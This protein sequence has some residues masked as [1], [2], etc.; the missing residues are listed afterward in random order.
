MSLHRLRLKMTVLHLQEDTSLLVMTPT[1]PALSMFWK[2][3][4]C[5][6]LLL[7]SKFLTDK[8]R[9]SIY[10]KI[11]NHAITVFMTGARGCILP[12]LV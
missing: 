12:Y 2:T 10:K 5:N 11:I 8:H 4:E 1:I 6:P 9:C 3:S 7:S